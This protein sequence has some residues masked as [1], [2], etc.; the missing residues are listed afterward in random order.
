MQTVLNFPDVSI[1]LQVSKKLIWMT[2]PCPLPPPLSHHPK[3]LPFHLQVIVAS[4]KNLC[5][6]SHIAAIF[7]ICFA[8]PDEYFYLDLCY[9]VAEH[10]LKLNHKT[11]A[12][13]PPTHAHIWDPLLTLPSSA[14]LFFRL[15]FTKWFLHFFSFAVA[16]ILL[17]L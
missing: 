10:C 12:F 5:L 13:L 9:R 4:K 3:S 6:D 15:A 14:S 8:I 11:T 1:S 17:R 2:L 7:L 16:S